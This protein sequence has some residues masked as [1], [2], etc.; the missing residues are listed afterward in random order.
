VNFDSRIKYGRLCR[1]KIDN[2]IALRSKIN[3]WNAQELYIRGVP[4]RDPETISA[5]KGKLK[6]FESDLENSVS[7][8]PTPLAH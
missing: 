5:M 6:H 7:S 3:Q 4:I 1:Q 8:S 2:H